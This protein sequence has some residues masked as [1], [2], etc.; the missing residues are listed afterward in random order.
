MKV[1]LRENSAGKLTVYV[2]KKDLEEEV[3]KQIDSEA[4]KVFTLANG[5]ELEISN[6]AEPLKIPQTYEARRVN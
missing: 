4:G 5:W 6:L 1:M 3:V 2:P